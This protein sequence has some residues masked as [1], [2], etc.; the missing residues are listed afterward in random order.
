MNEQVNGESDPSHSEVVRPKDIEFETSQVGRVY[1]W[2][3]KWHGQLPP[4][5]LLEIVRALAPS[6]DFAVAEIV[7]TQAGSGLPAI[8]KSLEYAAF[9]GFNQSDSE[10]EKG[11]KHAMGVAVEVLRGSESGSEPSVH[12]PLPTCEDCNAAM[13][14]AYSDATTPGFFPDKCEK[15]RVQETVVAPEPEC[16]DCGLM[17]EVDICDNCD[18]DFGMSGD[19]KSGY[20]SNCVH[21]GN[22]TYTT[23][24][25]ENAFH[26]A[27]EKQEES[28]SVCLAELRTMFPGKFIKV[29]Q[30][31]TQQYDEKEDR[32]IIAEATA[33]IF[34]GIPEM[35][36]EVKPT[37][38]EAMQSV[39]QWKLEQEENTK[40]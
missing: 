16:P 8:I 31:K 20:N 23:H 1:A 28:V 17:E 39:R 35:V 27:P 36:Y 18:K 11:Y 40:G 26:V 37:L 6:G 21:C 10:F 4:E 33:W 12:Q 2:L 19:G 22:N 29:S 15:H 9:K 14:L 34:V 25:C 38:S 24:P 32:V 5:S 30:H 3:E 13:R 7:P